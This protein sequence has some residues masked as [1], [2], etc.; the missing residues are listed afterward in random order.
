MNLRACFPTFTLCTLFLLTPCLA[1]EFGQTVQYFAQYGIGGPAETAFTIHDPGNVAILVEVELINSD[2]TLFQMEEVAVGPGAAETVVFS[3][4]KGEVRNGWARLTSDHPFSATVFFRIVGVGNVGV[5]P[6]EQGVKFKL[7]S[8][9]DEGTDTGFAVAN[10]SETEESTVT[11][12]IFSTAGVFQREVEE[13]YGPGEHKALFVTQEP[14]LVEGDSL[15]EFTATQ[16]VII[17]GLR[18]DNNLLA[19]TAVIRP[20]GTGLEPGSVNTEHLVDGAVTG[21]KIAEGAVTSGKIAAG[22]VVRSLNGLTDDVQL[23]EGDNILITPNGNT[24]TLSGTGGSGA[25]TSVNAGAG[26]TGGGAIGSVTLAVADEG[27]SSSHLA[28]EVSLGRVQP[29]DG[30]ASDSPSVLLGDPSNSVPAGIN[31]A[32]IGGGTE[33]MASGP[34]ATIGG[35]SSNVASGIWSTLGGGA[36]NEATAFLS[37]ISGG[38][39]N[40]ASG[41]SS[42]V[43]GGFSNTASGTNSM[44]GGGVGNQA[45]GDDC[46][47]AGGRDNMASGLQSAVPGGTGNWA[48][49]RSS[50]AAGDRARALH[51]FSFVWNDASVPFASTRSGQFL[52]NANG[53]V[54]IRTNATDAALTIS[55]RS[56]TA[57]TVQFAP[58]GIKGDRHSHIHWGDLGDWYIRSAS[59]SGNV[60]LQDS[61]GNV[62]IGTTNPQGT[63]D[64]NGSIFQRGGQLH[65]DYVF[66]ED[67]ALESIEEHSDYMWREKH[68]AA[69][70]SVQ[71]DEQGQEIVEYGARVRGILEELE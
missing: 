6:S 53:G 36:A 51:D 25:I 17:L 42:T 8:F 4:P 14:L 23:V 21:E 34:G 43:G 9:V 33:N 65:A 10:T 15:I 46:T 62:G 29:G 37:T 26:L 57:G 3:D 50:F 49:G 60:F 30:G 61:G 54:G 18:S 66:E 39:Q 70:S 22:A 38:S 1:G 32:T 64:V 2:G 11:A 31:G 69:V 5:L 40:E 58:N 20:E 63:L 59:F 47:V 45:S 19:S 48:S 24:L 52:I 35:G 16:P 67:Y 41:T 7:F 13:T 44:V 28:P 71:K 27:I 56:T 55:G 68:L 12:R